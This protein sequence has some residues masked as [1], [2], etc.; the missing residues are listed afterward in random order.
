MEYFDKRCLFYF[1]RYSEPKSKSWCLR[2]GA[3]ILDLH[4][5]ECVYVGDQ[6]A[7]AAAAR[8]A[9]TQFLG[10][11]YGWG[12]GDNDNGYPK[13]QSLLAIADKLIGLHAQP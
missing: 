12:I 4:P 1:D 5:S 2:E 10:V 3:R 6:P 8:E 13:A 7:D 9:G 11:T